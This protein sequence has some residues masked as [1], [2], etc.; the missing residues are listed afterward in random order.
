MPQSAFCLF[1]F[2]FWCLTIHGTWIYFAFSVH[3]GARQPLSK[4]RGPSLLQVYES[5][6]F[7]CPAPGSLMLWLVGEDEPLGLDEPAASALYHQDPDTTKTCSYL[8]ECKCLPFSFPSCPIVFLE[9]YIFFDVK[10]ENFYRRGILK[11]A[12]FGKPPLPPHT[13]SNDDTLVFTAGVRRVT[14]CHATYKCS[15]LRP[16]LPSLGYSNSIS[17]LQTWW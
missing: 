8:Q 13:Q 5:D 16:S 14:A 10:K 2:Y 1:C 12:A 4:S 11:V 15:F 7:P 6:C 17:C 3:L 9:F